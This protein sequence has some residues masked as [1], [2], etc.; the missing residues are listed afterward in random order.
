MALEFLKS[1]RHL[2]KKAAQET[3]RRDPQKRALA[4]RVIDNRLTEVN[5]GAGNGWQK[6]LALTGTASGTTMLLAAV[7]EKLADKLPFMQ[8][9]HQQTVDLIQI[10]AQHL[11]SHVLPELGGSVSPML[12]DL[13]GRV[14]SFSQD[15]A[16]LLI[17]LT[18]GA[19]LASAAGAGYAAAVR[20]QRAHEHNLVA[21]QNVA[22][23]ENTLLQR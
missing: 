1:D 18:G 13:V 22:T 15:E 2:M 4:L 20:E 3:F 19:L 12:H 21:K 9:L 10:S 8:E 17:G 11:S 14:S 23:L 7:G 5:R 16:T 6:I